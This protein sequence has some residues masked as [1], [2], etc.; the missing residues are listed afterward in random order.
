MLKIEHGSHSRHLLS[1]SVT[2]MC[3]AIYPDLTTDNSKERLLNNL[4]ESIN[5]GDKKTRNM[6]VKHLSS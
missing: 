4:D 1:H 6:H 5:S 2:P 3:E